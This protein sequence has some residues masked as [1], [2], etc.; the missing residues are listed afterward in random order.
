L[1]NDRVARLDKDQTVADLDTMNHIVAEAVARQRFSMVLL[2]VFAALA[3]LQED[4][5]KLLYRLE[6]HSD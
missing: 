1:T 6:N 4:C 2:G 5:S 3:L